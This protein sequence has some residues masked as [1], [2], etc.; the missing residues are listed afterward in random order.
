MNFF[1][2]DFGCSSIKYGLVSLD[3]K[4]AVSHFDAL[5]LSP[6]AATPD[7]IAAMTGVLQAAP[8]F[9]AAGFGFPSV[10]HGDHINNMAI[11]FNQIWVG[12][13]EFLQPLKLAGFA[14]NDA[15]AAGLAEVYRFE[16]ADLRQGTTL[17]LT[18]GTGIG[19]ALFLDRKLLPNTEMG[20]L[21]L[22]GMDAELY[23][24]P[25]VKTRHGLTLPAWAARLQEYL[26]KVE[27][28]QAPDHIVLGGGI[29]NDFETYRSLLDLQIPLVPAYYRNQAGVIGAAMY[30]AYKTGHYD[31]SP[32]S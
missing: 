25:S 3:R 10:V 29:S 22:H 8:Y 20:L 18:L 16:A 13:L 31:L 32:Q 21:E 17:V 1:G 19:S 23:A 14:L 4:I 11:Q 15:D 9:E 5:P 7:F 30:A 24:A 26:R 27:I 12:V 28:L 2:I 6:N